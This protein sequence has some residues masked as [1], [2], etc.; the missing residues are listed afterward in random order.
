MNIEEFSKLMCDSL[1]KNGLNA[2]SKEQ[3]ESFFAFTEI[4]MRVNQTTNLTAIRNVEDIIAKHYVDSM[5]A[6]DLISEGARVLDIGC[7]P[8][9]PSIPLAITRPDLQIVALDSTEKKIAFVRDASNL[10]SLQNLTTISGRAEDSMIRKQIGS[11]D[12]VVSRAV[13]RLNILCEL[14]LPYLKVGGKLIAMKASKADEELTEAMNAIEVLGGKHKQTH[15][16]ILH[17]LNVAPESRNLIEIAK[18]KKTPPIYP[19]AYA[20]ITKK[21]L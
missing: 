2:T 12:V 4:L 21:P 5:L 10:L 18:I 20:A 9:F 13:A 1:A 3:T 14:C 6:V 17:S 8:G 19:R 15:S 11:V 16:C 7:G